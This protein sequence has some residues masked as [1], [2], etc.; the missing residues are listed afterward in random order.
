MTSRRAVHRHLA[1]RFGLAALA[2]IT[3]VG[4]AG[5]G[6]VRPL[7]DGLLQ[8]SC[9]GGFHDWSAC[10]AA[11]R[12]HCGAAGYAIEAQVSDE[13]GS[14]GRRDWSQAGSEVSRS[15]DFRC[16]TAP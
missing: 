1:R 8:V 4:C 7:G 9:P 11:A 2:L 6:K 14:V 13:G 15:M 10:H 16:N 3:L 12:R 5:G